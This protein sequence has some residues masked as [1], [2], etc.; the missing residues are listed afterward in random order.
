M[1]RN[2]ADVDVAVGILCDEAGRVLLARRPE[3]KPLSGYLEFPGGKLEG[4]EAPV[5]ALIRE[6]AE[7]IGV[8][9][10]AADF[11]PLIRFEHAYP[12]F[13]VR[14]HAYTASRWQ[15]KPVGAEGQALSW[16]HRSDLPDLP[17]LPANR[18]LLNAL[19]LP[20]LLQVT[21]VLTAES[22]SAFAPAL[23]RAIT[24]ELA[25]SGSVGLVIRVQGEA[26]LAQLQTHLAPVLAD[27]AGPVLLNFGGVAD[28]L[29]EGFSGLHLPARAMREVTR[30]PAG[31]G[32]TGASV[33][34]PEE[35]RRAREL[36]L[37]YVI[38]GNV[39]S[40]PSHPDRPAL[41]WDRFEVIAQAAGL[42]AYAIGGV[43]PKD[44]A[45]A[46]VHW[47]QGV[48]GIRAFWPEMA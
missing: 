39:R 6:L 38:A 21:P 17:L 40:T 44:L 18:P 3:G 9:A 36:G 16:H 45:Q 22:V 10:D 25:G 12:E 1:A 41:G 31:T 2:P 28:S 5:D 48:A 24:G 46:R 29:P 15:G 4:S 14:L 19:V 35:A 20:G 27:A 30:R 43:G 37:D 26:A 8:T 7:E 23:E 42:P 13:T 47:G 33:H 11:E 34:T 32:L